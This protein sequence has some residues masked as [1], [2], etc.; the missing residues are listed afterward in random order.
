[1]TTGKS[2]GRSREKGRRAIDLEAAYREHVEIIG[3]YDLYTLPVVPESLL[4]PVADS[5]S[6]L[7]HESHHLIQPEE[8]RTLETL[9]KDGV[10]PKYDPAKVR[11]HF[12]VPD[13][14]TPDPAARGACLDLATTI[15][16]RPITEEDLEHLAGAQP[17]ATVTVN[18]YEPNSFTLTMDAPDRYLDFSITRRSDHRIEIS[19]ITVYSNKSMSS[20]FEIVNTLFDWQSLGV[21]HV[22]AFAIRG[23]EYNGYDTWGRLG[24]VGDIPVNGSTDSK[25]GIPTRELAQAHF[26]S[27]L[28]EGEQLTRVEQLLC[29]PGG[30]SWWKRNG[31]SWDATFDLTPGSYSMQTV[32]HFRRRR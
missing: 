10:R 7:L 15:F 4:S 32:E 1:M 21:T 12:G 26:G 19:D 13:S 17:G 11:F 2:T 16:G 28:P 8:I 25:D 27:L 24:C 23:T 6:E 3:Q 30:A 31:V 20:G 18:I 5:A 14:M 9:E 29:L 22:R